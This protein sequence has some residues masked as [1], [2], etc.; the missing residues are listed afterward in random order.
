MIAYVFWFFKVED[1]KKLTNSLLIWIFAIP[2]P[3]NGSLG[4]RLMYKTRRRP[5]DIPWGLSTS[6]IFIEW[7]IYIYK[8]NILY[9]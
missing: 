8:N 3:T 2:E 4:I 7:Y 6:L 1:R 5:L 9:I